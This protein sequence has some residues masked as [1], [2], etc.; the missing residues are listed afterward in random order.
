ML[1]L[2]QHD[3]N[4]KPFDLMRGF[5]LV[6]NIVVNL[7]LYISKMK[8]VFY[9]LILT[10]I[11]SGCCEEETYYLSDD[12]VALFPYE[13]VGSISFRDSNE[14]LV[15]FDDIFF[16]RDVYEESHPPVPIAFGPRCDDSF[17]E[18][19]VTMRSGGNY[20]LYI[21][22]TPTGFEINFVDNSLG[23]FG[24][25]YRLM[26]HEFISDYSYNDTTYNNVLRLY[27]DFSDDEAFFIRDIGLVIMRFGNHEFSLEN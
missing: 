6:L 22:G 7:L 18:I 25:Y 19:Y 5:F 12:E 23:G 11:I 24:V 3:N 9:F 16:E 21:S 2:V 26:E 17:E 8:R 10:L 13:N 14:N 20:E 1:K 15:V 27:S 4:K